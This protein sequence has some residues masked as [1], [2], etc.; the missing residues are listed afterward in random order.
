MRIELLGSINQEE[1]AKIIAS[2]GNLS[3]TKGTVF[4]VFESRNNYESNLKLIKRIIG[5]G[6][7]SIIEHDYYVFGLQ[8]IT[9]IMEQILIGYRLS[10][11]TVK[12]R[13]EVDFSKV[14]FYTPNF[15]D[16]NHH[17]HAENEKLQS[18]YEQYMNFLF[19]QY[20]AY[21][22]LGVKKEEARFILPYCYYSNLIMGMDARELERLTTDLLS[23]PLEEARELG[24]NF[25]HIIENQIPYLTLNFGI[26]NENAIRNDLYLQF[27][28][29]NIK[30]LE[31]PV[32]LS[33]TKDPDQKILVSMIM[34]RYQC[35]EEQATDMYL[36]LSEIQKRRYMQYL[37][38]NRSNRELEQVNFQYQIPISLAVLTHLTR[39][40]MHSLMVPNFVPLWNFDNYEIPKGIKKIDEVKYHEIY[41]KNT[42]MKDYFKSKGVREEDL[43]YFYLSGHKCNVLTTLNGSSLKWISSLRC[44]TKAQKEIR[45]LIQEMVKQTKVVAPLFGSGLGPTCEVFNFCPEGKE[46]CGKILELQKKKTH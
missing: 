15:H 9:P 26:D 27:A 34:T 8:D 4:E 43:V 12:S 42:E 21:I 16:E 37:I 1:R 46:C 41:K 22:G 40:R 33:Y 19:E 23:S 20:Q 10:S 31:K 29:P 3:R 24:Q 6:H 5:M 25:K 2:A 39:H 36:Q 13:R 45:V 28:S 18:I 44:C 38:E 11:F 17:I 35:T 7:K 30:I 14:G 32:L